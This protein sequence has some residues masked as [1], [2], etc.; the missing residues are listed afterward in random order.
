MAANNTYIAR[1]LSTSVQ[2]EG[3]VK[4]LKAKNIDVVQRLEKASLYRDEVRKARAKAEEG[5]GR[6]RA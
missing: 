5:K 4:D 2:L 3:L 1:A 6:G